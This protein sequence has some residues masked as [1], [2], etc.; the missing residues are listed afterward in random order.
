ML[1]SNFI[2]QISLPPDTPKYRVSIL[3]N[4]RPAPIT[5]AL[6]RI[7]IPA[8]VVLNEA[9]LDDSGEVSDSGSDKSHD[10]K[11]WADVQNIEDEE[12]LPELVDCENDDDTDDIRH[13]LRQMLAGNNAESG[14]N[15]DDQESNAD[16]PEPTAANDRSGPKSKD[17]T[18]QFC[19]PIH[20]LPILRLFAKHASQ[21]SL[22]PE[23]HGVP[24]TEHDIRR[25]AVTELYFHCHRNN[26]PEVW[27]YMWNNWY[28]LDRWHLWV[29][30]AHTGCISNHRTMM[31]VEALWRNLKRLVLHNYN[32]PPVDLAVYALVRGSIPPYRI[33]LSRFLQVRAGGRPHGL[34]NMQES[35]KKAWQRLQTVPIKGSYVTNTS[36]WTCNCGSQKYHAHLLCKHLV[37]AVGDIPPR[38]WSRVHRFYTRPFYSVPV[39]GELTERSPHSDRPCKARLDKVITVNDSDS[40]SDTDAVEDMMQTRSSSPDSE[41]VSV[42]YPQR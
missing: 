8:R 15:S 36:D 4:G 23:R 12:E 35:F 26:L 31:M 29:R 24:R 42:N 16:D 37:Q 41:P 11:Y 18:Y 9:S 27:A 30:S 3:R 40:D 34:S 1:W 7:R 25:D 6:P 17:K 2:G 33:T 38:W 5:P 32:R 20:R 28:A 19:P 21:H 10:G 14:N 22:L 39:D 13:D